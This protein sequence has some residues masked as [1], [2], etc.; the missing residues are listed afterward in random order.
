MLPNRKT[1]RPPESAILSRLMT[2]WFPA[3]P[4]TP[5][6]VK[7]RENSRSKKPLLMVKAMV[8]MRRG[9]FVMSSVTSEKNV[10]MPRSADKIRK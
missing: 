7:Y 8:S 6:I 2:T 1:V 10:E 9:R 3:K 4:I 5:T